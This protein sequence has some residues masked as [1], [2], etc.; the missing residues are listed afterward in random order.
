MA[1]VWDIL[2]KDV[3]GFFNPKSAP[4]LS[5]RPRLTHLLPAR[6]AANDAS[7]SVALASPWLLSAPAAAPSSSPAVV[8]QSVAGV[9]RA[10]VQRGDAHSNK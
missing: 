5:H 4:R 7:K 1:V 3:L 9:W 6:A 2:V 8:V 10:A